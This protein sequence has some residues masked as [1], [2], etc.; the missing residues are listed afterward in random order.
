MIYGCNWSKIIYHQ[1][2]FIEK[3]SLPFMLYEMKNPKILLY[4]LY[5]LPLLFIII[6]EKEKIK[7]T[8]E[9]PFISIKRMGFLLL[10]IHLLVLF[11]L[12]L[13]SARSLNR[14]PRFLFPL[15]TFLPF[16]VALIYKE[17]K[18]YSDK[19]AALFVSVIIL[20]NLG[21]DFTVKPRDVYKPI[22][23][24][25]I[26]KMLDSYKPII[27]FLLK[28]RIYNIYS[29]YWIGFPII[30][31]SKE[32]IYSVD[33]SSRIK[34]YLERVNNSDKVAFV[35]WNTIGHWK[36]FETYLIR[37]KINFARKN[38]KGFLCYYDIDVVKLRK[39]R[40]WKDILFVISLP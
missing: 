6:K 2:L 29:F 20:L 1:R 17:L 8:F 5:L 7:E 18:K 26:K 34:D 13:Q 40:M 28:K 33:R 30:F 15:Y 11:S 25:Y 16:L 21:I 37:S 24:V 31:N 22:P 19:I 35:F 27:T 38:I 36:E 14:S 39:L 9:A 4:F 10:I 32:K 23:Y 12:Y 3:L